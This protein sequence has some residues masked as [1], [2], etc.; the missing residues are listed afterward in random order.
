MLKP[1]PLPPLRP[2]PLPMPTTDTTDTVVPTDTTVDTTVWDTVDTTADTTGREKPKLKPNP[3]LMP[4]PMPGTD[5]TDADGVDTTVDTM[6]SVPTVTDTTAVG[7][8]L[9][10]S[11][12]LSFR[13]PFFRTYEHL[14]SKIIFSQTKKFS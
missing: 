1:N 3:R 5:T 12:H 7:G 4:L 14:G 10:N 9:Q 6:V 8:N 11:S 13:T 2:I